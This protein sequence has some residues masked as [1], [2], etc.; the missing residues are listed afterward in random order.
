MVREK[1]G[2]YSIFI[3]VAISSILLTLALYFEYFEKI[4]PCQLCI[5]QR[6]PHAI[7]I[8]LGVI[9]MICSVR[10]RLFAAI[11]ACS[12]MV[13]GTFMAGYHLGIEL[14]LWSGPSSCANTP[15][16]YELSPEK[17]LEKIKETPIISCGKVTWSLLGLSMA[18]WNTLFSLALVFL[19]AFATKKIFE[20]LNSQFSSSASQ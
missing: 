14:N 5:M 18:G 6:Y 13:L 11:L 8:L 4:L 3:A 19:W 9:A 1:T 10:I 17:M 12:L 2:T 16:D 20:S 7:V 15:I